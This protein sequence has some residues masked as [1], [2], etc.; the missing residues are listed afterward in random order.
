MMEQVDSIDELTDRYELFLFDQFGVLHDGHVHYDGMHAT[1]ERL[2]QAGKAT[3][4]I[5]NSGKREEYNRQ[6]LARFGYE[7]ELFDLVVSS[8]EVAW[9]QLSG[10]GSAQLPA[11]DQDTPER[12]LRVSRGNDRSAVEGLSIVETDNPEMAGLVLIAGCNSEA[13]SLQAYNRWLAPAARRGVPALC[14]NP[15]RQMLI[16]G[17]RKAFGPGQIAESYAANG[18]PVT[19]VGKPWPAIYAFACERLGIEREKT[20]CI[21]DSLEHDIAGAQAAGCDSLLVATG[22]HESLGTQALGELAEQLSVRPDWM[23]RRKG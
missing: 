23:I 15:D 8:G 18:G 21:G 11:L 20:L 4:V 1:L 13:M 7:A 19:Y 2:K 14:T 3:G 5:T 6:R 22:V 9:C 17:G 12:V 10:Q 16:G